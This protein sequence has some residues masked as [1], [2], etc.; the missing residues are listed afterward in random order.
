[1]VYSTGILSLTSAQ[2]RYRKHTPD[3]VGPD[4]VTAEAFLSKV[5][6]RS[7][8]NTHSSAYAGYSVTRFKLNF[9]NRKHVKHFTHNMPIG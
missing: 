5:T 4:V 1:M 6:Y 2:L 3:I 8:T 9:P 7:E